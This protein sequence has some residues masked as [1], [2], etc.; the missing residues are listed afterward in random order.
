MKQ[1]STFSLEIY[2]KSGIVTR[3]YCKTFNGCLR[4][5]IGIK[6]DCPNIFE[7]AVEI[8]II[9]DNLLIHVV[10]EMIADKEV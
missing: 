9:D 10:R 5:L 8:R 1:K 3:I 2:G 4:A 7:D 6:S